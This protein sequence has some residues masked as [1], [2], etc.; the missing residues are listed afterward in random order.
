M[1]CERTVPP[2]YPQPIITGR[3]V[4]LKK[5]HMRGLASV[6]NRHGFM[7]KVGVPVTIIMTGSRLDYLQLDA[8]ESNSGQRRP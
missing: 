3:H 8:A 5:R 7:L 2:Y 4:T 6:E 1:C